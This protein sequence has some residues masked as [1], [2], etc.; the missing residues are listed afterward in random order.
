MDTHH[1]IFRN[2]AADP[3]LVRRHKLTAGAS[4]PQP[5]AARRATR[6]SSSRDV[7]CLCL[8]L[9]AASFSFCLCC[10][11]YMLQPKLRWLGGSLAALGPRL[12]A[13][14]AYRVSLP[15]VPRGPGVVGRAQ[16]SLLAA[17]LTD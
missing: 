9:P 15:R 16:Q 5:A 2:T 3:V 17:L 4:P 8:L 10:F 12:L 11:L 7:C 14:A 1:F 13:L 6:A